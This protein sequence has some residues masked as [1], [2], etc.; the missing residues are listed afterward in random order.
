MIGCDILITTRQLTVV[1]L[2]EEWERL[3]LLVSK[4]HE[5]GMSNKDISTYLNNQKIKPRRNST[6]TSK[7]IWGILNKYK[8]RKQT[9]ETTNITIRNIGFYLEGIDMNSGCE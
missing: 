6:F 7:L 9:Q 3:I 5:E 1:S 8:K 2:N 4:L